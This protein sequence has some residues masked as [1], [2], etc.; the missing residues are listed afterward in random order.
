MH[1]T[2]QT[3]HD[4][5]GKSFESDPFVITQDRIVQFA[6]AT[7]YHQWIDIYEDRAKAGPFGG[8]VAHGYLTLSLLV[9]LVQ[10][11]GLFPTNVSAV[12]NYG[13]NKLRFVNPVRAGESVTLHGSLTDVSERAEGQ[14]LLMVQCEVK[15]ESGKTVLA[16]ETLFLLVA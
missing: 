8:T 7:D 1:T 14:K 5:V 10:S 9:P 15:N 16:A 13:L 6:D 4:R 12:I 3:I 2:F 11:V